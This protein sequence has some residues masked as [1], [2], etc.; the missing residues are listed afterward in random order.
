MEPLCDTNTAGPSS[1][2]LRKA[3][4]S[5][6]YFLDF[7]RLACFFIIGGFRSL[8]RVGRRGGGVQFTARAW[9]GS[10]GDGPQWGSRAGESGG[11]GF[12]IAEVFSCLTAECLVIF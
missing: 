7:I 12:G 10:W 6:R 2:E 3:V 4:T 8:E 9:R 5:K 1:V 11:V